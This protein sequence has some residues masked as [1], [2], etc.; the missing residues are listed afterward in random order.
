MILFRLQST[1]LNG[2]R[3]GAA[4]TGG[5]PWHYVDRWRGQ[6]FSGWRAVCVYRTEKLRA[7]AE[8]CSQSM[9]SYQV[10]LPQALTAWTQHSHTCDSPPFLL[11]LNSY[12]CTL[13]S[14][15]PPHSLAHKFHTAPRQA[16]LPWESMSRLPMLAQ[17]L[18]LN[19]HRLFC[20]FFS[21]VSFKKWRRRTYTMGKIWILLALWWVSSCLLPALSTRSHHSSH[22]DMDC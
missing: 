18:L 4:V 6:S 3:L 8:G 11:A 22:A 20:V 21:I 16:S 9:A 12:H 13:D 17:K 1:E 7:D 15:E 14:R 19:L 10:C 2:F 5:V